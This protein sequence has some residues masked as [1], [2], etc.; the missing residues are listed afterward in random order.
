M[1]AGEPLPF[2]SD[3]IGDFGDSDFGEIAKD[4]YKYLFAYLIPRREALGF[5]VVFH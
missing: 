3:F 1:V 2:G 4:A 5:T